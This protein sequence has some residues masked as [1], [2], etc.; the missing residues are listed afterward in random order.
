MAM[1]T[2]VKIL[3]IVGYQ[4]SG[5]TTLAEKVIRSLT[6]EGC[7]VGSIKHHGHGGEPEKVQQKDSSRH[8]NAGAIASA[9][10]GG[11]TLHLHAT[12]NKWKLD[13]IISL[14]TLLDLDIVIIEG[15]KAAQYPKVVLLKSEK[16]FRLLESSNHIIGVISWIPLPS[17]IQNTYQTFHITEESAYLP[18]LMNIVREKYV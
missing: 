18:W 12:N 7:K 2:A 16:D 1:G 15:Y 10:E 13:D 6:T 11:G 8:K 3:Q 17:H 5:K 14:Y 9:V 4:N